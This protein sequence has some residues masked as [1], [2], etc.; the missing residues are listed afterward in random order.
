M[1][2][3]EKRVSYRKFHFIYKTTCL[4]TEKYYLG[5]HSTDNMDDGYLGSGKRL[6][7]SISKYG[8]DNHVREVVEM[9]PTREA[10][11]ER[12]AELVDV[13]RLKDPGCMNILKGGAA[14]DEETMKKVSESHVGMKGKRHT[15][16][17]KQKM[18]EARKGKKNPK[19]SES[20]K[21]RPISA[22]TRK[23]MSEKQ[24][25]RQDLKQPKSEETKQK[26]SVAL[27]GQGMSEERRKNISEATKRAMSE[28]LASGWSPWT[29]RKT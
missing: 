19:L 20:L 6:K 14:C 4:V 27:K 21:G 8:R 25:A 17:S 1:S 7:Y 13:D 5:M 28:K 9:L 23:K 3:N 10:L 29:S 12:E 16:E 11:V 15:E 18:S 26:I 22:E 24:K 2:E